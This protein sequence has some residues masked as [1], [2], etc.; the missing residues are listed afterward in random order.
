MNSTYI[1]Y[2]HMYGR[3]KIIPFLYYYSYIKYK[4]SLC[5]IL[6]QSNIWGGF[7]LKYRDNITQY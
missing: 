7:N 4:D 2:I 6:K 1:D 5:T 3:V